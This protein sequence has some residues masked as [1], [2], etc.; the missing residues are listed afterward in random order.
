MN[1]F[2]VSSAPAS[3]LP[4]M[5]ADQGGLDDLSP[6]GGLERGEAEKNTGKNAELTPEQ[7]AEI[8]KLQKID[9]EVRLH[10]MAHL[11]AGAGMVT[12]GASYTYKRGPDGQN[13]AV[14]GEVSIDTSPGRTPEETVARAERI[15][16]AALAPAD[17]SPQDRSVAAQAAQMA[18]QARQEIAREQGEADEAAGQV[19][20]S[21]ESGQPSGEGVENGQAGKP[22]I[23]PGIAAYQAQA[24]HENTG[25]RQA[26]AVGATRI[27]LYG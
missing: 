8:E 19:G 13:Y 9:R 14:A 18:A 16:A 4:R 17:P 7:Q 3:W 27:D 6:R 5:Q 1:T 26:P 25:D 10:E 2:S 21:A 12:S 11:A 24:A 20:K 22:G 15:Q 23:K